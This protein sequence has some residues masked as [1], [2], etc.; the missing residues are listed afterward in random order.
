MT[1]TRT[2]IALE[3]H[4]SMQRALARIIDRA[5]QELPALHWVD[6]AGIHL[7]L[8]FLG[9]LDDDQLALAK[10]ATRAAAQD[11]PSFEYHLTSL[12]IFG[13][14]IQ[15]RVIWMGIE[16]QP[17]GQLHGSPLQ[18]LRRTL[19][20][21]LERRNFEVEKRPFSPHLT[22]ARIK[23]S[24]SPIEQQALQRLLHTNQAAAASP[25]YRVNHLNVMRS[26]LSRSGAK[27][28]V[29]QAYDLYK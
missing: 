16:D 20:R 25:L 23:Q 29:L 7:T 12:G 22:L 13:S 14:P 26:E 15:P 3:M 5:A 17:S 1:L 28:S 2:F 6:P 18:Q 24:L 19:N 8:A 21:E 11:F 27:Y 4:A 9:E 10:E